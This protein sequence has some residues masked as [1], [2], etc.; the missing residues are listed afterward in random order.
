MGDGGLQVW[1][2]E[3]ADAQGREAGEGDGAQGG[4]QDE[5]KDLADVVVALEV[6]QVRVATED[7]E[8]ERGE[9]EFLQVALVLGFVLG[10][11]AEGAVDV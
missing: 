4:G 9:L 8:D 2:H 1:E 5:E 11:V 3:V 10:V 7:G 6:V